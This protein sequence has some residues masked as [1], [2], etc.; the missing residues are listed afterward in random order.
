MKQD[1]VSELI[2]KVR[3]S[4]GL[5]QENFGKKYGVTYQAVSKWENGKNLPDIAILKEICNDYNIDINEFLNGNYKVKSKKFNFIIIF[6][7]LL[8]LILSVGSIFILKNK[9]D[10][11]EF[12]TIKTTCDN[13]DLYGSIAYSKNK[14]SIYISNITYCGIQNNN[15]YKEIECTLYE[16]DGD[17]K[18]KID[19]VIYNEK[20]ITL[21]EFL[22]DVKFNV[23]HYSSTCKM[24]KEN[25]LMLE[26]KAQDIDEQTTFYSLPLELEDN[27]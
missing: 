25:G 23:E 21:D 14:T 15:I 2:K 10:E 8:I 13:F 27:C 26:I 9:K 17:I 6:V 20:N 12:K 5:S 22:K 18:T 3:T 1:K 16:V 11:F 7:I 4:A 19:S 24:Y